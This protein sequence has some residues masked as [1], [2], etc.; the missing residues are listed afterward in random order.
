MQEAAPY[1]ELGQVVNTEDD[2]MARRKRRGG[3][4]RK[5]IRIAAVAGAAGGA[6]WAYKAYQANGAGGVIQSYSGY[7]PSDGSFNIMNATS[8][9]AT[10]AGAAVSM[11]GAKLGLNKYLPKGFGI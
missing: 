3:G 5:V 7:N 4:R 2:K 1:R 11:V 10:I 6:L 9:M 8:L